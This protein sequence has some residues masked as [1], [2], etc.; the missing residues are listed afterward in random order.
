MKV[1]LVFNEKDNT[2]FINANGG[3]KI[4]KV[5]PRFGLGEAIIGYI[6]RNLFT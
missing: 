1:E 3:T 4:V 6:E 2:L 5:N